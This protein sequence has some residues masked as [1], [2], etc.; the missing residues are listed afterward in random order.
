MKIRELAERTGV[1][2][3]TIR[4]YEARGVLPPPKRLPNGYRVYDEADVERLRFVLGARRLGL[5]LDD[6]AEILALRDRG[7]AP[8]RVV[9]RLLAE[10]AEEVRRRIR[11]L[12]QLEVELRRLH[13][14]GLSFPQDDIEGKTCVCHLVKEQASGSI[15]RP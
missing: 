8:C 3:R 4:F 6:I 2:P 7:E 9:L 15:P 12:E 5:G 13:A 14:L 10:K 11:E 1:S